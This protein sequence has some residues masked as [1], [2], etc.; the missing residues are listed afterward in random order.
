MIK[1][2]HL[3]IAQPPLFKIQ[4]GKDSEYAFSEEE[5]D[6][7]LKNLLDIAKEKK[8]KS[9]KAKGKTEPEEEGDEITNAEADDMTVVEN[10]GIK[11]TIQ[12]YKGLGEMNPTQL[13]ETTM[14]PSSRVM[15]KVTIEDAEKVSEIF[16]TLMGDEVAPRKRFITT[17]AKSVKNLDI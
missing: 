1:N 3:Y 13:W 7:I 14:D 2:G 5:R 6:K 12:R 9:Q 11:Y 4:V 10:Q 17:H 15:L 16:E 8:A